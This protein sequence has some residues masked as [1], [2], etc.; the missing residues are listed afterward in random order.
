MSWLERDG[1]K[2]LK[3]LSKADGVLVTKLNRFE[4]NIEF[5]GAVVRFVLNNIEQAPDE[6]MLGKDEHFAG[7]SVDESGLIFDL[8][9]NRAEKA[10]YFVLDAK[11]PVPDAFVRIK[12]KVYLGKRT[13]FV[14]FEDVAL[15]RF[16][17]IAVHAEEVYRNSPYDGPFDQLPE[18][19]Y[20]ELGFWGY[21]YDAYPELVGKLT[22]GG[23]YLDQALIF[24]IMPYR[25][26]VSTKDLRFVDVCV[27]KPRRVRM[28]LCLTEGAR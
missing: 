28:I 11:N 18:N 8:I 14:F 2:V 6:E 17:L 15:K 23:S 1:E 5:N 4:Y 10:F 26:Y 7:R 16:I 9:Y 27:K 24:G 25:R 20:E 13:G 22:A 3:D 19:F 21:V 12:D